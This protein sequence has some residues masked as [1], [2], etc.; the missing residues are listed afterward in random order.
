MA[1]HSA[2]SL[3]RL[4]GAEERRFLDGVFRAGS[5]SVL[6]RW[7]TSIATLNIICTTLPPAPPR[8][9]RLLAEGPKWLFDWG[10]AKSIS[11]VVGGA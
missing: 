8:Q 11:D 4:D 1:G 5:R 6:F 10:R 2:V 7:E 9:G 3:V